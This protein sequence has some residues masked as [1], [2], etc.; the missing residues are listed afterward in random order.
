MDRDP[1]PA[2]PRSN[3]RRGVTT[4]LQGGVVWTLER[5]VAPKSCPTLCH[6]LLPIAATDTLLIVLTTP[7]VG[8]KLTRTAIIICVIRTDIFTPPVW[9]QLLM[10]STTSNRR[11]KSGARFP[12]CRRRVSLQKRA[13]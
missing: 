11:F 12:S 7:V 9:R 1:F 8:A 3:Y 6:L 5:R 4:H 10:R 2:N 13:G